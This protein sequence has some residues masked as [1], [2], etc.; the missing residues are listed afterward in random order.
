MAVLVAAR[1]ITGRVRVSTTPDNYRDKCQVPDMG[2]M[3]IIIIKTKKQI[4]SVFYVKQK[5]QTE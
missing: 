3:V 1:L 2:L 4:I 5:H